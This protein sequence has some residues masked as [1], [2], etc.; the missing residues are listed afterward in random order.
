MLWEMV[1]VRPS[2]IVI[3]SVFICMIG[4]VN[5]ADAYFIESDNPHFSKNS[6]IAVYLIPDRVNPNSQNTNNLDFNAFFIIDAPTKYAPLNYIFLNEISIMTSNGT[7]LYHNNYGY[8]PHFFGKSINLY[9]TYPTADYQSEQFVLHYNFT[10]DNTGS[11][12][13]TIRDAD[14]YPYHTGLGKAGELNRLWIQ[15]SHTLHNEELTSLNQTMQAELALRD[16]Q[17]IKLEMENAR[18]QTLLNFDKRAIGI[19][20]GDIRALEAKYDDL[21]AKYEDLKQVL[22]GLIGS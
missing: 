9:F 5:Q 10:G 11:I 21:K 22:Q 2:H 18:Q 12:P 3:I 15:K 19:M 4:M 14:Y 16:A 13:F 6:T 7:V 8:F 20:Q 1:S 17:I